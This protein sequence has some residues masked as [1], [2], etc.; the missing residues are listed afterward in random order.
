MNEFR[1]KEINNIIRLRQVVMTLLLLVNFS[2]IFFFCYNFHVV[3]TERKLYHISFLNY[4]LPTILYLQAVLAV[5]F[6]LLLFFT[7]RRTAT[8]ITILRQ[9]DSDS[10][11]LYY[12]YV[13]VIGRFWAGIAPYIFQTRHIIIPTLLSKKNIPYTDI[14]DVSFSRS[15]PYKAPTT[16]SMNIRTFENKKHSVTFYQ[17]AQ[18]QFAMHTLMDK[19]P[20]IPVVNNMNII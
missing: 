1:E 5:P 12:R 13:Q 15:R 7:Y 17:Y 9:L 4:I 20:G 6:G 19:Q 3:Y 18:A 8:F 10:L 11:L 2:I 16:Y 14:M